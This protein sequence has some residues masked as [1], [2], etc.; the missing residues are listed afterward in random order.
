[1]APD[2]N[3]WAAPQGPAPGPPGDGPPV[4][5]YLPAGPGYPPPAV[6][7][8]RTRPPTWAIVLIVIGVLFVA[9][10]SIAAVGSKLR[11]DQGVDVWEATHYVFPDRIDGE[12]HTD[13]AATREWV[14]V[15][16]EHIDRGLTVNDV[17]ATSYGDPARP[18]VLV[19]T[20]RPNHPL[21][22]TL[23]RQVIADNAKARPSG[24]AATAKDPGPLGGTL[25][26]GPSGE[27]LICTVV[28]AAGQMV[29]VMPLDTGS[30]AEARRVRAAVEIPHA[31]SG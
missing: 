26:C 8:P 27:A 16:K 12:T 11:R 2:E 18:T 1:M 10:F 6:R 3:V 19:L 17:R 15:T 22:P 21:N 25:D 4:P 23:Q 24:E 20:A 5:G 30:D 29:I 31:P 14:K 9:M 13:T 7:A 28:D